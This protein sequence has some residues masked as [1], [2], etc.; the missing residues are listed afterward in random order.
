MGPARRVRMRAV[1][2]SALAAGAAGASCDRCAVPALSAGG[3]CAEL[4]RYAACE[5]PGGFEAQQVQAEAH[6]ASVVATYGYT[7]NRSKTCLATVAQVQCATFFPACVVSEDVSAPSRALSLCASACDEVREFC[8]LQPSEVAAESPV[9]VELFSLDERAYAALCII[10]ATDDVPDTPPPSTGGGSNSSGNSSSSNSSS[11]DSTDECFGLGYSGPSYYLWAIGLGLAVGFSFLNAIALNLQKLSMRRHGEDAPVVTQPL[12]LLG[13]SMTLVGSLMDFVALGLAPAS[14]LAPLAALSLV[15]NMVAAP[16]F[17]GERLGRRQI[18]A[19]LIIFCGAV[20]TVVFSSHTSPAY[21]LEVLVALFLRPSMRIYTIVM[22]SVIM[23]FMAAVEVVEL[24]PP[25]RRE[26]NR[27]LSMVHMLG[28]A[29][30]AGVTG[31][32]S[33]LFAKAA[34]ELCKAAAS[35]VPGIGRSGET[36]IIVTGLVLCLLVQITYLNGALMY[37]NSLTV[38]PVYQAF[39]IVSGVLGGLVYFDEIKGFGAL[40][41]GMFCLGIVITIGGV[42]FLAILAHSHHQQPK[43]RAAAEVDADM[44]ELA[45]VD[46]EEEMER[47]RSF[48]EENAFNSFIAATPRAGAADMLLDMGV[49]PRKVRRLVGRSSTRMRA[50]QR[51]ELVLEDMGVRP[52]IAAKILR[53]GAAERFNTTNSPSRGGERHVSFDFGHHRVGSGGTPAKPP[54]QDAGGTPGKQSSILPPKQS[55]APPPKEQQQQQQQQ[56]DRQ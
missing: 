35:G 52:D 42:A 31:G 7:L 13:F 3:M 53:V 22:P 16:C 34:M 4:V 37:H 28:Y 32:Q 11:T 12:W 8:S 20:V 24:M 25:E 39:W 18:A 38:V 56:Q 43:K 41:L 48:A 10:P 33:I 44:D 50:T 1:L 30:A 36:Y 5:G 40:Q 2:G 47:E 46:E 21:S 19:T 49:E 15:W 27:T 9:I 14:L 55:P 54:K 51:K 26:G 45:D 29:G 23:L 17:L 6:F